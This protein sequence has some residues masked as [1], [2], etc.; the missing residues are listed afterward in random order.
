MMNQSVNPAPDSNLLSI[1]SLSTDQN[2]KE[3]SKKIIQENQVL[4]YQ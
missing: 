3:S 2:T 4:R 1:P